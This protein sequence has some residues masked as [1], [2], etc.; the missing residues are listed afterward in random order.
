ML[1]VTLFTIAKILR[2]HRCPPV[3]EWVE[4]TWYMHPMRKN[5][6]SVWQHEFPRG[7]HTD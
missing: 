3:D 5:E 6:I 4:N 7:N 1:I 2:Q